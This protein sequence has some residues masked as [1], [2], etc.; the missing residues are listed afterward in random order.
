[1]L[2]WAVAGP[3]LSSGA[4]AATR[5]V[6]SIAQLMPFVFCVARSNWFLFRWVVHG[7]TMVSARANISRVKEESTGVMLRRL[8]REVEPGGLET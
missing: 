6:F 7:V 5:A 3:W 8:K 1:M 2:R 4:R